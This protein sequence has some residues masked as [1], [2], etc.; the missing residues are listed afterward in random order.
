[1]FGDKIC[2][3]KKYVQLEH[4]SASSKRSEKVSSRAKESGMG[5]FVK[6][7]ETSKVIFEFVG[8]SIMFEIKLK[9]FQKIVELYLPSMPESITENSSD[10]S[11][12]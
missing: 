11:K 5:T 9:K 6:S 1:M 4:F 10:G 8:C 2:N 7:E 3:D 12:Y